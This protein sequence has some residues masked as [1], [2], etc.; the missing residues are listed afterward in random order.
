MLAIYFS[1]QK[2]MMIYHIQSDETVLCAIRWISPRISQKNPG[3]PHCHRLWPTSGRHFSEV[4]AG[5]QVSPKDFS[6]K[7]EFLPG[8]QTRDSTAVSNEKTGV[9]TVYGH[10]SHVCIYTYMHAQDG[11]FAVAWKV[12]KSMKVH[13]KSMSSANSL[14]RSWFFDSCVVQS[15]LHI[16]FETIPRC[17]VQQSTGVLAKFRHSFHYSHQARFSVQGSCSQNF[18]GFLHRERLKSSPNKGYNVASRAS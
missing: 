16:W 3:A 9:C 11:T 18:Y 1:L 2:N 5:R 6:R 7:Q 12:I 4:V 13:V 17:Q 15:V 10:V 14:S 8:F